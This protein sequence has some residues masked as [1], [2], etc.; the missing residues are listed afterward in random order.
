MSKT[1]KPG[2]TGPRQ[3]TSQVT[4][5]DTRGF[6]P[7]RKS[8][9]KSAAATWRPSECKKRGRARWPARGTGR[10]RTPEASSAGGGWAAAAAAGPGL[11]SCPA[12]SACSAGSGLPG[13]RA[14]LLRE[15]VAWEP[16]GLRREE[17]AGRQRVT[18]RR[19]AWPSRGPLPSALRRYFAKKSPCSLQSRHLQ[20][21]GESSQAST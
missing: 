19:H 20:Y 18:S 21:R 16:G 1:L 3:V 15:W 6:T 4:A 14:S 12:G 2:G 13:H 5:A 17:G 11:W 10:E 7:A 8:P 9:Q